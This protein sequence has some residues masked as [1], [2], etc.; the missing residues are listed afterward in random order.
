[1]REGRRSIV[2]AGMH[3]QYLIYYTCV[4]ALD[5]AHSVPDVSISNVAD[6]AREVF[7]LTAVQQWQLHTT[8][9]C[10]I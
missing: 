7:G 9:S 10:Y 3:R 6:T 2:I 5:S 4:T 1:M 8:S